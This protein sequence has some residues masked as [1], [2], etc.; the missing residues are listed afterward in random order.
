MNDWRF[1]HVDLERLQR[2]A[3]ALHAS[4]P[5]RVVVALRGS[6][7]AG[8]TR[9][10][11]CLAAAA[12]IDPAEVT[13][14]TFGI[15]HH[16]R[17]QR[18]IHHIDAYRLADEDEFIELGGEELLE[19]D[20]ALVLIEWPERIAGC[21]PPD[22][23]TIELEIESP[24]EAAEQPSHVSS[25]E[26]RQSEGQ[27]AAGMEGQPAAGTRQVHIWAPEGDRHQASRSAFAAA[28]QSLLDPAG[29][30]TE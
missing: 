3:D 4:L 23:W 20:A 14:P 26:A 24:L 8:K 28:V 17:G 1:R 27:P 16:H 6:L 12:G 29:E 22:H 10:T 15:V 5:E 11:Q 18:L 25:D 7:G 13:S 30:P 19:Q 9:L 21:L 2:I